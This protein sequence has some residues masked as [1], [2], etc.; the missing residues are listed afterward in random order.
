[1]SSLIAASSFSSWAPNRSDISGKFSSNWCES[2]VL[3][4]VVPVR[5]FRRAYFSAA[6]GPPGCWVRSL[7]WTWNPNARL[8]GAVTFIATRPI[9]A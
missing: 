6:S 9:P 8:A 4:T 1:M 3:G 7:P 5:L 2:V